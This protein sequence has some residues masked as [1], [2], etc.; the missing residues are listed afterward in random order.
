M[1]GHLRLSWLLLSF[2]F[3]AG[4]LWPLKRDT[5]L[6][7]YTMTQWQVRNGLP[8]NS[9]ISILQ[10]EDG[11]L[12]L[13][14][15]DG[16]VRFDGI[17]FQC[18]NPIDVIGSSSKVIVG[19]TPRRQ[20][21]FY[22]LTHGSVGVWEKGQF[23]VLWKTGQHFASQAQTIL[24]DSNGSLWIGT[25]NEGLFH[26]QGAELHGY[27]VKDGLGHNNVRTLFQ[28][29]SGVLWVGTEGGLSRFHQGQWVTFHRKDGLKEEY[30]ISLHED[31][32]G[33]LWI[34]TRSGGLH[35]WQNG[36]ILHIPVLD[37]EGKPDSVSCIASEANGSLWLGTQSGIRRFRNG[38]FDSLSRKDGLPF[39]LMR[40]LF[41]DREGNLW[42]GTN[43]GG[44]VRLKDSKFTHYTTRN[45]LLVNYMMG[46]YGSADGSMWLA[47]N[48]GGLNWLKDGQVRT[49]TRKDG[50]MEDSIWTVYGDKQ[51]RIW[52]GSYANGLG[53]YDHGKYTP[54]SEKHG[55]DTKEIRSIYVDSRNRLWLGARTG[56]YRMD[57]ER[58]R[59]VT[60]PNSPDGMDI[61]ALIEDRKGTLWIGTFGGGLFC[62]QDESFS[63]FRLEAGLSNLNILSFYVDEQNALWIGTNGGGINRMQNGRFFQYSLRDGLPADNI[64]H[65][66]EDHF[67]QLWVSHPRGIF[68]VSRKQMEEY[69]EGKTQVLNATIYGEPDGVSGNGCQGGFQPAGWK[70][71]QGV[72]WFPTM[73]GLISIDPGREEKNLLPPL[74]SIEKMVVDG[75]QYSDQTNITLPPGSSRFEIH[76]SGLCLQAAEKVLFRNRLDG[77]DT[78]W[79]DAGNLP[80]AYYTALPPGNYA[81]HVMACNNDGIWSQTSADL[82]FVIRPRFYQ[83]GWFQVLCVLIFCVLILSG[84]QLRVRHLRNR[85]KE[86][87]EHVDQALAQIKL[88]NGML[89]ICTSCKKVR[90][91]QG[92]WNQIETYISR[93]SEATF[94]HGLCPECTQRLYPQYSEIIKQRESE[95]A[96]SKQKKNGKAPDHSASGG[97]NR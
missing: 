25:K 39:D 29:R 21:G 24:E 51:G 7:H 11:Y 10:T 40:S 96:E 63:H 62:L 55:L 80:T 58:F 94:S 57:G 36:H 16:L 70:D 65:I 66:L 81:F 42:L 17:R 87:K 13:G 73:E 18:F 49:F 93:H 47:T 88:L 53:C 44:L 33:Q 68:R 69:A 85:G 54:Y 46:M 8:N 31:H 15:Y 45:G 32:Q 60:G 72:L 50:L 38:Q 14:T 6:I 92:Y 75:Q 84:H 28:D 64:F 59:R 77:F 12:W 56:L 90:D 5:P 1:K 74:V 48:G 86:L 71:Q 27:S 4:P 34:G 19:L 52:I 23:A 89:P 9:V 79:V 61:R 37:M 41:F 43:G 91:D 20:G 3:L 95:E 67:G 35:L 2:F 78:D 82:N 30:V 26:V 97:D 22:I 83:S 76:Y